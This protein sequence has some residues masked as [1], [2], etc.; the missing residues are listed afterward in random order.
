MRIA[1]ALLLIS[2]I[3]MADEVSGVVFDRSAR[4]VGAAEVRIVGDSFV[5]HTTTSASGAFRVRHLPSGTY[6][7][8]VAP[9]L[10]V[11]EPAI[12]ETSGL[13]TITRDHDERGW[14]LIPLPE[15]PFLTKD[16]SRPMCGIRMRASRVLAG[17]VR[18]GRVET[19]STQQGI[20]IPSPG[21]LGR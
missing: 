3:C 14:C 1:L 4:P 15:R 18:R 20:R 2:N 7:I 16:A 9:G 12:G 11:M 6:R 10:R 5:L 8:E 13:I 19:T 21:R 17:S